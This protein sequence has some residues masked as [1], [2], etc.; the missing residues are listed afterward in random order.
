MPGSATNAWY[1]RVAGDTEDTPT[2]HVDPVEH[3]A[4]ST[5]AVRSKIW[6]S[7]TVPSTA[8]LACAVRVDVAPGA[9]QVRSAASPTAYVLAVQVTA[10]VFDVACTCMGG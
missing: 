3:D 5:P 10:T 4:N 1:V 9:S 2:S 8:L 6:M 7:K